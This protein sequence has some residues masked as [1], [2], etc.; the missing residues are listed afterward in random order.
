MGN[1]TYAYST[2]H[3]ECQ[4]VTQHYQLKLD[5]QLDHKDYHGRF[6]NGGLGSA[7]SGV[8]ATIHLA[9]FMPK[10]NVLAALSL[11]RDSKKGSGNLEKANLKCKSARAILLDHWFF[12]DELDTSTLKT[13]TKTRYE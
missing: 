2:K 11:P 12:Y 5:Y 8:C 4:T 1:K 10:M 9:R 13:E 3:I 6:L 7:D